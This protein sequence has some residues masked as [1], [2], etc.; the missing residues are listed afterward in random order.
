MKITEKIRNMV[1]K[2]TNDK[3]KKNIKIA[4]DY[5]AVTNLY[6]ESI[7]LATEGLIK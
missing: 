6:N 2:I 1:R 7:K 4:Y 3:E 5:T